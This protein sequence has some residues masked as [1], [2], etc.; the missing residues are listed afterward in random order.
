MNNFDIFIIVIFI[1]MDFFNFFKYQIVLVMSKGHKNWKRIFHLAKN[2]RKLSLELF[3][4]HFMFQLFSVPIKKMKESIFALNFID[5]Y[6]AQIMVKVGKSHEGILIFN[7]SSKK[8]TK[9]L[10][11]N[12]LT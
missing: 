6:W 5:L 12:F 4:G 7:P 8:W 2:G 3:H 11:C 9:S 10:S 1:W